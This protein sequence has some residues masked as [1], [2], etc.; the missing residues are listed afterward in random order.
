MIDFIKPCSEGIMV[1][2]QQKRNTVRTSVNHYLSHMLAPQLTTL[3]GRKDAVKKQLNRK[4]NVPLIVNASHCFYDT[5]HARDINRTLI[6]VHAVDTMRACSKTQTTIEFISGDYLMVNRSISVL[7]N[8]HKQVKNHLKTLEA[9][10]I[11][12]VLI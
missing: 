9:T 11:E 6:N 12:S 2:S 3:T 8:R 5:H 10:Q 4:R 7:K 1:S